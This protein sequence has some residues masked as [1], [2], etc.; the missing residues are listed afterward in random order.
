MVESVKHFSSYLY[1]QEFVV[2][3]DHKPLCSLLTSDHLNSRLKR[4][5]TKLQPWMV[6]FK[7]LP[8]SENTFADALS[9]Q[10][11]RRAD[12][13]EATGREEPWNS[14]E[15]SAKTTTQDARDDETGAT[16]TPQSG[17]GGCGGPAPQI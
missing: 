13:E 1:G 2:F 4:L 14:E 8:G 11:W 5:S 17:V 12:S 15:I 16:G 6:R 9:R 7:Y 3:T 10:D